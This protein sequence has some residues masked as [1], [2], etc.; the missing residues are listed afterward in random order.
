MQMVTA[1]RS[2]ILVVV[3]SPTIRVAAMLALGGGAF[4]LSNVIP[5]SLLSPAEFGRLALALALIQV[6]ATAAALGRP[7]LIT[8][9]ALA[10]SGALLRSSIYWGIAGAFVTTC[11]AAAPYSLPW[12]TAL[13]IGVC[14]GI[15]AL[16]RIGSAFLQSQQQLGYSIA[17]MQSQNWVLLAAAGWVW[18]AGG[19]QTKVV[20]A[21][22]L[23]GYITG[24]IV[25]WRQASHGA[26]QRSANETQPS[27]S[28]RFSAVGL[29][30]A[31]NVYLQLDRL[32]MGRVLS[33]DELATYSI[34]A[35]IAGSTF[36]MLQLGAG[37]SLVP[38]LRAVRA[39]AEAAPV[40]HREALLLFAVAASAAIVV[41]VIVRLLFEFGLAQYSLPSGLLP[42]VVAVGVIRIWQALAASVVTALGGP[43]ELLISSVCAWVSIVLSIV[44]ALRMTGL[45]SVGVVYGIAVGSL[46]NALTASVLARATLRRLASGSS[47]ACVSSSDLHHS[48][49]NSKVHR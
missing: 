16:T 49:I 11:V 47:R 31:G 6:G 28:E 7:L 41:T 37:F 24:S 38:R 12:S 43:R 3:R 45:G 15:A 26:T 30:V 36:R 39:V 23:L 17:T 46:V 8:R 27:A 1:L 19:S 42:A 40:V 44:C 9:H 25:S 2:R 18:L 13:L 29:V 20:L 32:I 35:A 22:V 33:L 48:S 34:V 5:A 21:V 10:P 4:A 14:A